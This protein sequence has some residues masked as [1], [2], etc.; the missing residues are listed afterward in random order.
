MLLHC[1]LVKEDYAPS[2]KTSP[3]ALSFEHESYVSQVHTTTFCPPRH[4]IK[5]SPEQCTLLFSKLHITFTEV[6]VTY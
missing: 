6:T 5:E 2:L 4:A 1:V 3:R